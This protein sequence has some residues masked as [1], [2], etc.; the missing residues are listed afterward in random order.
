M[1]VKVKILPLPSSVIACMY[2]TLYL[3]TLGDSRCYYSCKEFFTSEDQ[4]KV[5]GQSLPI[6]KLKKKKTYV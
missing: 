5:T 1:Q 2:K 3:F 4:T 6:E